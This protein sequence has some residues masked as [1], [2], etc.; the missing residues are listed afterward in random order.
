MNGRNEYNPNEY[1]NKLKEYLQGVKLV[2][3]QADQQR[4]HPNLPTIAQSQEAI[5]SNGILSDHSYNFFQC[6]DK[7]VVASL[8]VLADPDGAFDYQPGQKT[9]N[10]GSL[11]DNEYLFQ[12]RCNNNKEFILTI[13]DESKNEERKFPV[14]DFI[15]LQEFSDENTDFKGRHTY[16]VKL[17][18]ELATAGDKMPEVNIDTDTIGISITNTKGDNENQSMTAY[19]I[20]DEKLCVKEKPLAALNH[21]KTRLS[22]LEE[23]ERLADP[24]LIGEFSKPEIFGCAK[25]EMNTLKACLLVRPT[26]DKSD[27]AQEMKLAGRNYQFN[28]EGTPSNRTLYNTNKYEEIQV[29]IHTYMKQGSL[30]A[31]ISRYRKK[32]T[33]ETILAFNIH[34][35][36]TDPID[37]KEECIASILFNKEVDIIKAAIQTLKTSHQNQIKKAFYTI[38]GRQEDNN[39]QK[40]L[41]DTFKYITKTELLKL[42]LGTKLSKSICKKFADKFAAK[43]AEAR[44]EKIL[45]GGDFN[46]NIASIH[47]I[48]E[49]NT[50]AVGHPLYHLGLQSAVYP[51]GVLEA[52]L[53][54]E[55]KYDVF[56]ANKIPINAMTGMPYERT[57]DVPSEFKYTLPPLDT[58]LLDPRQAQ[59][60]NKQKLVL[61]SATYYREVKPIGHMRLSEFQSYLWQMFDKKYYEEIKPS[62]KFLTAISS[63]FNKYKRILVLGKI[64]TKPEVSPDDIV[65][66]VCEE[67]GEM[68]VCYICDGELV[69]KPVAETTFDEISSHLPKIEESSET[70]QIKFFQAKFECMRYSSAEKFF[71]AIFN[72][73]N[74]IVR[75]TKNANNEPGIGIRCNP[76]MQIAI[77]EACGSFPELRFELNHESPNG[78]IFCVPQEQA[79]FLPYLFQQIK[80]NFTPDVDLR[81]KYM[82]EFIDLLVEPSWPA[83]TQGSITLFNKL[84]VISNIAQIKFEILAEKLSQ[85]FF[86]YS[87]RFQLHRDYKLIHYVA[88]FGLADIL[89]MFL[90]ANANENFNRKVINEITKFSKQTPLSIAIFKGDNG[91]FELLYSEV[92]MSASDVL[93]GMRCIIYHSKS[94]QLVE[95]YL[96]LL[97]RILT[98][99]KLIQPGKIGTL[100]DI[101]LLFIKIMHNE[102]DFSLLQRQMIAN[103]LV[104][105]KLFSSLLINELTNFSLILTDAESQAASGRWDYEKEQECINVIVDLGCE[106]KVAKLLEE[107]Q[108]LFLSVSQDPDKKLILPKVIRILTT[109]IALLDFSTLSQEQMN[110]FI[111]LAVICKNAIKDMEVLNVLC[112]GAFAMYF[113]FESQTEIIPCQH[114]NELLNQL[115]NIYCPLTKKAPHLF[116]E[117]LNHLVPFMLDLGL[118]DKIKCVKLYFVALKNKALLEM[119]NKINRI[120]KLFDRSQHSMLLE[121]TANFFLERLLAYD[122]NILKTIDEMNTKPII[123]VHD[124]ASNKLRG[125]QIIEKHKDNISYRLIEPL[126]MELSVFMEKI[127]MKVPSQHVDD[128]YFVVQRK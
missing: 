58:T 85:I 103:L 90:L 66:G 42:L 117:K 63:S 60:I 72:T 114:N 12:Q 88:H 40:A 126:V 59:D 20:Q 25:A 18:E 96:Y 27:L 17:K 124:F 84:L 54:L 24:F 105:S 41:R 45:I 69:T 119:P 43:I 32:E 112:K 99:N 53:N 15:F 98:S 28:R 82:L 128:A 89:K 116:I 121:S 56:Q 107:A 87:E 9:S 11:P 51:D 102:E 78:T 92:N 61:H 68:K 52:C 44:K 55:G 86:R 23:N 73:Q 118:A 91:I 81:A 67:I 113:N 47:P 111:P 125:S 106:G 75:I 93:E 122:G 29:N 97:T 104:S 5:L 57:D 62:K 16:I 115:I 74:M 13:T 80:L 50:T 36:F 109:I 83:L 64:P 71:E 100:N 70:E 95:F 77:E 34:A 101:Q 1:K 21:L 30:D 22:E 76:A 39:F 48:L 35:S 38:L 120:Q 8:N 19:W 79:Y 7:L 94:S 110:S 6:K 108:K 46:C 33:E 31:D 127:G 10:W 37:K 2:V 49:T 14:P 26:T 123:T 4:I 3:N 65:I